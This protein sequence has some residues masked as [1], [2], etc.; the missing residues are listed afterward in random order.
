MTTEHS[1]SVGSKKADAIALAKMKTTT[2]Y[3]FYDDLLKNNSVEI[4]ITIDMI[5]ELV[6][7]FIQDCKFFSSQKIDRPVPGC[8]GGGPDPVGALQPGHKQI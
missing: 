8:Q 3:Q 6:D 2:M 4:L 5:N 7:E 1:S